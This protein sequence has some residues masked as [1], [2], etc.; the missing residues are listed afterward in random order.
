M[1][2]GTL[3]AASSKATWRQQFEITDAETG[4][5]IDIEADVDE[6]AVTFRDPDSLC[7]VVT[8]TLTGGDIAVVDDGVFEVLVTADTMDGLSPKTYEVG[9]LIEVDDDTEQLFLGYLPVLRGL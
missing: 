1:K 4:E 6:I 3:E 5:P 2:Q 8:T 9:A 7:D